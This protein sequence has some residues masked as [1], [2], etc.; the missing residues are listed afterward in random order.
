MLVDTNHL[1]LYSRYIYKFTCKFVDDIEYDN[2]EFL[3]QDSS[4]TR[5]TFQ[6]EYSIISRFV[7]II[8]LMPGDTNDL[9]YHDNIQSVH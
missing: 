4:E 6:S 1:Q 3:N 9:K 8:W 2:S 5:C 7:G